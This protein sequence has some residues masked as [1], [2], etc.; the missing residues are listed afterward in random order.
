MQQKYYKQKLINKILYYSK[1]L[2]VN[3]NIQNNSLNLTKL[4]N[5]SL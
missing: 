3:K 1:I 5:I 2:Y 4:Y